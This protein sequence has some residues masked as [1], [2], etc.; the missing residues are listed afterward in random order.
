MGTVGGGAARRIVQ[1]R[2]VRILVRRV[3]EM[4]EV[5]SER[6]LGKVGA[7]RRLGGVCEIC[8]NGNGVSN[9][10]SDRSSSMGQ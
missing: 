3:T 4:G 5:T 1:T 7:E 9:D 2:C 6:L 10:D 8:W